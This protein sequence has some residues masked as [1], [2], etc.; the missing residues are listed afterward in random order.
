[1]ALTLIKEA[2]AQFYLKERLISNLNEFRV[3]NIKS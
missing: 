3:T 1:M 2:D